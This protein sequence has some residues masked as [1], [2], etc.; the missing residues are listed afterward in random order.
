MTAYG[1]RISDWGSGVCSSDLHPPLCRSARVGSSPTGLEPTYAKRS[2]VNVGRFRQLLHALLYLRHPCRRKRQ[3]RGTDIALADESWQRD[4]A[5]GLNVRLSG[6]RP[7][8]A[9]DTSIDH[10]TP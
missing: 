7:V 10:A 9:A 5:I 4:G 6:G 1:M 2:R 8:R 3:R